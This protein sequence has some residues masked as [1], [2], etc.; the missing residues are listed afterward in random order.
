MKFV[1]FA[2]GA[3][4]AAADTSSDIADAFLASVGV[5]TFMELNEAASAC[6]GSETTILTT[7]GYR[8]GAVDSDDVSSC[9]QDCST[10]INGD[11]SN[12]NTVQQV[13]LVV[14]CL[15][16]D[17]DG[18][19]VAPTTMAPIKRQLFPIIR[20]ANGDR[21]LTAD[22]S[23]VICVSAVGDTT[24]MNPVTG[25]DPITQADV[26]TT[27]G[28]GDRSTTTQGDGNGS[29]TTT[30]GDGNGS[31]TTTEGDGNG[32]TTTTEGDGNGSTTTTEG[33]GNGSTTTQEDGVTTTQGDGATDTTTAAATTTNLIVANGLQM[34][35][36][37][38]T[39]AAVTAVVACW[40]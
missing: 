33:D 13:E 1:L 25:G 37:V 8:Y 26:V 21:R 35:S 9:V 18:A 2:A 34:S 19:A 20:L 15:L 11:C 39:A 4:V 12:V 27:G 3:A 40:N 30:Q 23:D 32:S 16:E 36:F 5:T 6:G 28:G 17:D 38:M 24:S 7:N 10:E 22:V 14:E 31:T 29:T